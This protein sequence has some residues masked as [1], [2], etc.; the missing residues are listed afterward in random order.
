MFFLSSLIVSVKKSFS[1]L[2]ATLIFLTGTGGG[3][4]LSEYLVRGCHEN[5]LSVP[6]YSFYD[7]TAKIPRAGSIEKQGKYTMYLAKNESEFCQF[8]FRLREDRRDISLY[9]SDFT[10]ENGDTL[11]TTLAREYY[12]DTNSSTVSGSYPDAIVPIDCEYNFPFTAQLN[13]AYYIGVKSTED[14]APGLY[15]AEITVRSENQPD[16]R[17]ENLKVNVYA[18]V[19]DFTLP[20]TPSM[21]T[22]MGLSKDNIAKFHGVSTGS[23]EATELYKA[24][25]EFLL[26]HRISAYS[27]PVDILSDEADAYMSDPRCTSF[28]I[29]Y[30]SDEYIQA[31]YQKLSTHPDWAAKAYFYPID[32]PSNEDA[33]NSYNAITERLSRLYPGYNMVTPYYMSEVEIGGEKFSS[34]SLQDGK[35]SII[36]PVSNLFSSDKFCDEAHARQKNGD[37]LWWYVC[38]GPAP[39]SN[40]CNLFTQFDG[41]RHR[42]LF[43]QQ[44]QLNITGLL[45]WSTNYWNDVAD[46][47]Q[48]SWTTPWTGNDTFGDG[49]L[50]YPGKSHGVNGPVSSLR[51]EGILNGIEDYEYLTMAEELLGKDYTDKIIAK[52]SRDLTNYTYSDALFAKV[53]TELGNAIEKAVAEQG[54][55]K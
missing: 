50:L 11:E 38:C 33:Y 47:W 5:F 23:A 9:L 42:L 21:D 2:L 32:E 13:Y 10:N 8:V 45:Y 39:S 43:W 15:T 27:L 37:K 20:D 48:S 12:V 31:V 3:F 26:E 24:Y 7:A 55:V 52:V 19:W 28:E 29:P 22:A 35:S 40:Y 17:F 51:L 1:V 41:I 44:K 18:Y 54:T 16:N 4:S 14:S 53:R 49:S 6:S 25:Y 36:C 34:T 46:P 30:G